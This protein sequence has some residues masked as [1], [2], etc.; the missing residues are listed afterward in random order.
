MLQDT[1]L[2]LILNLDS[3]LQLFLRRFCCNPIRLNNW[4]TIGFVCRLPL[5]VSVVFKKSKEG[6][7]GERVREGIKINPWIHQGKQ[8]LPRRSL[9]SILLNFLLTIHTHAMHHFVLWRVKMHCYV[10]TSWEFHTNCIYCTYSHYDFYGNELQYFFGLFD[11]DKKTLILSFSVFR[12][13]QMEAK[14][15]NL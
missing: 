6:L 5:S 4:K 10:M 12:L 3:E 1:K 11:G 14:E 15:F 2:K 7:N 13:R 9:S 8:M